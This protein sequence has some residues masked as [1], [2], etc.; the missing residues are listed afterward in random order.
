MV[1]WKA[2][3][4]LLL[5]AATLPLPHATVGAATAV[6]PSQAGPASPSLALPG[7]G[8]GKVPRSPVCI[9]ALPTL[10]AGDA[11]QVPTEDGAPM[12]LR[13]GAVSKA[14]SLTTLEERQDGSQAETTSS[15]DIW[16]TRGSIDEQPGGRFFLTLT[17]LG[18]D[19]VLSLADRN[20]GI[21]P[22]VGTPG[23]LCG[24]PDPGHPGGGGGGG[25]PPAPTS[26]IRMLVM[27]DSVFEN[28][29]RYSCPICVASNLFGRMAD[30]YWSALGQD[31]TVYS[32]WAS[33]TP[34]TDTTLGMRGSYFD[35][36]TI[37]DQWAG[38]TKTRTD[39][40]SWDQATYLHADATYPGDGGVGYLA[41]RYAVVWT[42]NHPYARYGDDYYTYVSTRW[43]HEFGH[44][45]AA[46]HVA[47]PEADSYYTYRDSCHGTYDPGTG[48]CVGYSENC[49]GT[50]VPGMTDGSGNPYCI[51]QS[52]PV[53]DATH[54]YLM[55]GDG[56]E[57]NHAAR[58][59]WDGGFTSSNH[60]QLGHCLPH[61]HT[62]TY[63]NVDQAC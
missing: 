47:W 60:A 16:F 20:Y 44:N 4:V 34:A 19:G 26:R 30:F 3:A 45:L 31:V 8:A 40:A 27:W 25:T 35:A 17:P 21:T 38:V 28:L 9:P 24:T 1:A 13:L 54:Y 41:G 14:P 43:S 15:T 58:K 12:T 50:R 2:L 55:K 29:H 51:G 48:N 52:P 5:A 62:L 36:D 37:I 22:T 6:C 63:Q 56:G 61:W 49:M 11:F 46:Q 23:D 18:L 53:V 57:I 32:Y 39:K 59:F 33:S 10:K 7:C 42:D